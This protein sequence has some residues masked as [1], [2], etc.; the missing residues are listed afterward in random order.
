MADVAGKRVAYDGDGE[1]WYELVNAIGVRTGWFKYG[2]VDKDGDELTLAQLAE[3]YAIDRVV[4]A[5]SEEGRVAYL[6]ARVGE[7]HQTIAEQRAELARWRS[8]QRRHS[9]PV[10]EAV[11]DGLTYAAAL[12]RAQ[13][14]EGG[15]EHDELL[16]QAAIRLRDLNDA[17]RVLIAARD[18]VEASRQAWA[19]EAMFSPRRREPRPSPAGTGLCACL[20]PEGAARVA[21]DP[22]WSL[23]QCAVHPDG[24]GEIR[25]VP[26]TEEDAAAFEA[27]VRADGGES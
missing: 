2:G 8:G 26:W 27:Q 24:P 12:A 7:L 6:E 4:V 25:A 11:P 10:V 20:T 1:P 16:R 14:T 18:R 21:A 23:P 9:W 19:E 13:G 17:A 5:A 15:D 22:R 3:M